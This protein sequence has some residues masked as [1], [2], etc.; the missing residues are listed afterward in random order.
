MKLIPIFIFFLISFS[1]STIRRSRR[2]RHGEDCVSDAAC[3]EGLVCKTNRC[4]TEY[5]AS[6]LSILGLEEKNICNL[7][8]KCHGNLVCYQ[9]RCIDSLLAKEY[10]KPQPPVNPDE[11]EDISMIFSGSISLNKLAYLSGLN[12]D[13]TFNY[14]HLFQH[15]TNFIK[16]ADVSI[17]RQESL[18]YINPAQS[19]FKPDHKNIPKELGNAVA[20]AGFSTVLHATT[21]AYN[22]LDAGIVNT[23]SFWKNEHPKIQVLG[24][25][26]TEQ[27]ENDYYI[28]EKNGVKIAIIDFATKLSKS[29]PK[30]KKYMV[31]IISKEKIEQIMNKLKGQADF[32]VACV[33][34]G[35]KSEKKPTKNQIY[36]SK[37]LIANGVN[38]IVGNQPDYIQP[39]SYV[40]ASN[41]NCG[42]V[43]FSLGQFIGEG[44]G[45]LGA[46]A[47]VVITKDKTHTYISSYSLRPT[48][49]HN[50]DSKEY[51]VYRLPTYT[52]ELANLAKKKI[53][54]LKLRKI[55]KKLMGAFAYC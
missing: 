17:A 47:H 10:A 53:N 3:E 26:K 38:L 2:S 40:K 44:K 35:V 5:E 30:T 6:H 33:D 8:K 55:C 37:L 19:Q 13:K 31:N 52:Q 25:S 32:F 39:V 20:N 29:L 28:Y 50:I 11:E 46:F 22:R 36:L 7:Q 12:S 51:T 23:L 16:H 1:Q 27:M 41:G 4:F 49:N 54:V 42:L 48:I 14:D 9:H 43:F 21:N 24:I 34:W 15:V 18:F 45:R